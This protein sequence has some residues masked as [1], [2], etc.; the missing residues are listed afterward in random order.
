MLLFRNKT[1]ITFLNSD[2]YSRRAHL[3][4][5]YAKLSEKLTFFT[6]WYAQVRERV[7]GINWTLALPNRILSKIWQRKRK[8][9]REKKVLES[10]FVFESTLTG[11][12]S[13]SKS[14][15]HKISQNG[16]T[17]SI[18]RQLELRALEL[19]GLIYNAITF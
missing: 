1:D 19:K 3:F 16:Q 6:P 10:T 8:E 13:Y 7:M 2:G 4:N 5:T 18:C 15:Y 11:I 9:K 17:H 14:H 12:W